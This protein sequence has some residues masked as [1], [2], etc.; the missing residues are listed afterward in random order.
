MHCQPIYFDQYRRERYP[1]AEDLCRR[2]LYLPS[3][4][5]LTREDIDAVVAAIWESREEVGAK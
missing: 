2:G 5:G 1:V 4:S 3:A